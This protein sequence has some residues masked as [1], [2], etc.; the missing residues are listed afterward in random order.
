MIKLDSEK[1]LIKNKHIT[2]AKEEQF[3]RK[4]ERKFKKKESNGFLLR[5][6]S[7]SSY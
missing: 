7:N 1:I 3:W 5:F 2:H 6:A 4:G